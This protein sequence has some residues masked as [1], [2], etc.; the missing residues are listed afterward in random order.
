MAIALIDGDLV[1]YPLACYAQS[2]GW[3]LEDTL[4]AAS[5]RVTNI[6]VG[7]E[8]EHYGL[9]LSSQDKSNFRYSID[10]EYKANRK[11]KEQPE[12]LSQIRQHLLD[13]HDTEVCYGY[14]A[15]DALG[16]DQCDAIHHEVSTVICS[17]DK[18]LNMIPGWH[19]NWVKNTKYYVE[20]IQGLRHFYSQLLIGDK[21]DNI[22]GVPG[23]GAVKAA[24]LLDG[25][26]T[27]QEMYDAV[28]E[29]YDSI[30]RLH[31]NMR[32]LWIWRKQDDNPLERDLVL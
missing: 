27:E 21:A 4:K 10:P 8:C 25:L 32:L 6:M 20:E 7:A 16:L 29:K 14:E 30:E 5:D 12:W 23:I 31:K 28:K 13:K 22:F 17:Y 18:D 2:Q 11:D 3:S 24:K 9:Y 26:E 19:Y 15:D 1:A